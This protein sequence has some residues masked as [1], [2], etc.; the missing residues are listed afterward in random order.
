MS[1]ELLYTDIKAPV[2]RL[3]QGCLAGCVT[4]PLLLTSSSFIDHQGPG[5]K[6]E[7]YEL[8]DNGKPLRIP[9]HVKTGDVVQVC[10]IGYG[11]VDRYLGQVAWCKTIQG[12]CHAV[13]WGVF[14]AMR[15]RKMVFREVAEYRQ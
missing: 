4:H 1:G 14:I 9:M 11:L 8:N 6:W 2:H 10:H 15:N 13:G 5:K 7:H 12:G 3:Y